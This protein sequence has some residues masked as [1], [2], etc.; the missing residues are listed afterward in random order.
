MRLSTFAVPHSSGPDHDIEV[1]DAVIERSLRADEGGFAGVYLPEHHFTSYAPYSSN[2]MLAS[3]LAPQF[4]QA[5]LGLSVAV[6]GLHHPARLAEQANLLD[7]LT[8]GR[9]V[10]GLGTGGIHMES[11]GFGLEAEEMGPQFDKNFEVVEQL[12]AKEFDDEPV[13]FDVGHYRGT[14]HQRIMPTSYRRPHPIVKLATFHE[15][16]LLRAAAKG[17]AVFTTPQMMATYRDALAAAGH[18]EATTEIALRWSCVGGSIHVAETDQQAYQ[19][20]AEGNR[21]RA[22]GG[23]LATIGKPHFGMPNPWPIDPTSAAPVLPPRA[24]PDSPEGIN[25]VLHGSPETVI[26][27][28]KELEALSGAREAVFEF[29]WGINTPERRA[30]IDRSLQLLIDEVLPHFAA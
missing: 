19:E 15:D 26:A 23:R 14:L 5:H 10:L 21:L 29:D 1:I 11:L 27:K 2:F 12:W 20:V 17:W 25:A 28:L 3:Y 6:V 24:A 13:T 9:F 7:V 16:R 18:D 4:R 30:A 8:R 22:E